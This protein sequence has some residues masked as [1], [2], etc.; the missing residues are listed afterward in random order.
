MGHIKEPYGID[1][2]INGKSLTDKEKKAISEFIIADKEKIAKQKNGKK[3]WFARASHSLASI[4][5]SSYFPIP[6]SLA[7]SNIKA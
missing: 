6:N 7:F 5:N 4:T 3:S 2:V 1:F